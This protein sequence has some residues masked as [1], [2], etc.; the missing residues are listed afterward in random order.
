MFWLC[1]GYLVLRLECW[2]WVRLHQVSQSQNMQI[3]NYVFPWM[4]IRTFRPKRADLCPRLPKSAD[5][6]YRFCASEIRT[7]WGSWG[8]IRTF[9]PKLADLHLH[10]NVVRDLHE[11]WWSLKLSQSGGNNWSWL[12]TWWTSACGS[13]LRLMHVLWCSLIA[14]PQKGSGRIYPQL[15]Y[16]SFSS[17]QCAIINAPSYWSRL[18]PL[19]ICTHLRHRPSLARVGCHDTFIL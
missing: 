6:T 4:E 1:S 11:L 5:L 10:K 2:L 17:W 7:F 18:R 19:A 13:L 12:L 16:L 3:S 14:H 15:P 8:E 9:R